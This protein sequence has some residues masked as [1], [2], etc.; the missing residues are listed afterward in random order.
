LRQETG[1]YKNKGVNLT[2]QF[3]REIVNEFIDGMANLIKDKVMHD[4]RIWPNKADYKKYDIEYKVQLIKASKM[5]LAIKKPE[6]K[7]R[8]TNPW[9]VNY[10]V[11]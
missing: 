9:E 11:R 6:K 4:A 1:Y 5:L 3:I 10:L 7:K 2:N 8:V